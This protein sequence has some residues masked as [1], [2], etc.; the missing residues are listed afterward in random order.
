MFEFLSIA[1]SKHNFIQWKIEW[2]AKIS[3]YSMSAWA[4]LVAVIMNTGL[5]HGLVRL[6]GI[7]F[8]TPPRAL[9]CCMLRGSGALVVLYTLRAQLSLEIW[10]WGF[11]GPWLSEASRHWSHWFGPLYSFEFRLKCLAT[12]EI[13]KIFHCESGDI[14][15][16][17]EYFFLLLKTNKQAQSR[18]QKVKQK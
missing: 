9:L 12:N 7:S 6:L 2:V 15:L 1:F 5:D 18:W 14:T 10:P 8:F 11:G 17:K 16:D 4:I 13:R 3:M